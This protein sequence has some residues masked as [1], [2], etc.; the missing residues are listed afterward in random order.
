MFRT[1]VWSC[2]RQMKWITMARLGKMTFPMP[3]AALKHVVGQCA[4]APVAVPKGM[5]CNPSL[6]QVLE[7]CSPDVNGG[8]FLP[9]KFPAAQKRPKA[10]GTMIVQRTGLADYGIQCFPG[11]CVWRDFMV[12]NQ[13]TILAFFVGMLAFNFSCR[14]M[15]NKCIRRKKRL[16][17]QNKARQQREIRERMAG[18]KTTGWFQGSSRQV[19]GR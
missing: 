1:Y 18:E 6:K 3:T 16:N 10:F 13:F 4:N 12:D 14:A 15:M 11:C 17:Q 9:S 7:T 19:P 2:Y 5:P 8:A